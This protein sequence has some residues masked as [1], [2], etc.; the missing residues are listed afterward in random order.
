M[1]CYDLKPEK[2][3]GKLVEIIDEES[4]YD[5]HWGFIKDWDGEHFHVSGGS[6]ALEHGGIT[7]IFDR[8]QFKVPRNL[9]AFRKM[10]VKV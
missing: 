6:I 5:G 2:L 1:G 8:D 7:P 10:G 9:E 3:I 4:G